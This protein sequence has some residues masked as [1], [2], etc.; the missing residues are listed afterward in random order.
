MTAS[1]IESRSH[2]FKDEWGYL[3]PHGSIHVLSF[4]AEQRRL[5]SGEA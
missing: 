2:D 4:K 5:S 1:G 3:D